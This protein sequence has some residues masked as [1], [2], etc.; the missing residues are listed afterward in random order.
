MNAIKEYLQALDAL[1]WRRSQDGEW[2][3]LTTENWKAWN[4]G[5]V[6]KLRAAQ[7]H[8]YFTILSFGVLAFLAGFGVCWFAL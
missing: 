5:A 6:E 3:M 8:L 2:T 7:Y 4:Y 1:P